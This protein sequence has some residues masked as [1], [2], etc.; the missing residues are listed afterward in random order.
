MDF[1]GY[2][3]SGLHLI[4]TAFEEQCKLTEKQLE[5]EDDAN[6]E[7]FR[8][9]LTR[10]IW[11]SQLLEA[12]ENEVK[13]RQAE[14]LLFSIED[15]FRLVG[16]YDK[17]V[18][19]KFYRTSEAY[20]KYGAEI[21]GNIIYGLK[22]RNTLT[23]AIAVENYDRTDGNILLAIS[24]NDPSKI[25]QL[26]TEG[27]LASEIYAISTFNDD[28]EV[29][30]YKKEGKKEIPN[31]ITIPFESGSFDLP[32]MEN[33]ITSW[34]FG[35]N[36][37]IFDHELLRYYT[38]QLIIGEVVADDIKKK[39]LLN[40]QSDFKEQ[41]LVQMYSYG[42][43][44]DLLNQQQKNHF[45]TILKQRGDRRWAILK[46]DLGITEKVFQTFKFTYPEEYLTA[47]T[48]LIGFHDET[49]TSTSSQYPIYWDEE[50]FIHIYGRHYVDYFVNFSTYKGTHFQYTYKDIR[51]LI[52]LVL[53]SLKEPIEAALSTGRR[54]DKY[55]DQGYYFNG[56][57]YTLRIDE[58]GRLMT[59]FPMA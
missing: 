40:D 14:K 20:K 44:H 15:M 13:R 34:K 17:Y 2:D 58:T 54:F 24:G 50:R 21:H 9:L 29:V 25:Q 57:Y 18:V 12:A 47:R 7:N 59:F 43:H 3:L 36:S 51:R 27:F 48:M 38:N 8:N 46:K 30:A 35:D 11:F 16:Q 49:L 6:S 45:N 33:M 23:D 1:T 52:C 32:R 22:L 5:E 26:K 10:F 42:F 37:K 31:T 55:G 39:Y 41:V 4:Y 19:V 53:D 56:N 28:P